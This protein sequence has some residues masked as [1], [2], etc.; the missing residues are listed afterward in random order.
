MAEKK[1]N[2]VY[3]TTNLINGHQYIGD[4]SCDCEPTEDKYL[5]SGKLIRRKINEYGKKNFKKEIL[6][7]F[8]TKQEAF[9]AQ[10]KYI[11]Q[12]NTLIPNGY[13][14]SPSGGFMN[15]GNHSLESKQKMSE[16]SKGKSK[17]I[18]HK[19]SLSISHIGLI[20][21]ID[22]IKKRVSKTKGL[23]RSEEFKKHMSIV[24]K[25][26]PKSEE[27]KI[28]L[29]GQK[30]SE[31]TKNKMRKPH[32][33]SP[34]ALENRKGKPQSKEHIENRILKI[35]GKKRSLEVKENMKKG[36][37]KRKLNKVS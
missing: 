33:L 13:N 28:K 10:E 14:I 4:R 22:T 5:G 21:S 8:S 36:W 9:N 29:R 32:I 27:H 26:K 6:E 30:R 2:Y 18:K 35:R 3:I 19:E 31:D 23:K 16:A 15:G 25:G 34:E 12:F 37:I 17:S 7:F 11:L 24:S 20:Q 1:F